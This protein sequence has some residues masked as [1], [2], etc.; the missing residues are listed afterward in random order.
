MNDNFLYHMPRNANGSIYV[1]TGSVFFTTKSS[2][3]NERARCT[4]RSSQMS[5]W[6]LRTKWSGL[7]TSKTVAAAREII[8]RREKKAARAVASLSAL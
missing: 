2:V 1:A 8:Y 3:K 4:Q 7:R 5:A 6:H